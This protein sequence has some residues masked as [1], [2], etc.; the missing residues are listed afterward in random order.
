MNYLAHIFL[1]RHSDDA[2]VGALL[3]DFVKAGGQ[4]LFP[5]EVAR[6]IQLHRYIDS[7]TDSHPTVRAGVQLFGEGRRRYAGIVLDVFYDHLLSRRW[8]DYSGSPKA[9]LIQRFYQAVAQYEP[10][11]PERLRAILPRM[12]AQDWLGSYEDL[13]SVELAVNRIS[14]RL[15]RNGHLMREGLLDLRQHQDA[16]A[17]GFDQFFPELIRF[18]ELKRGEMRVL[19]WI[20]EASE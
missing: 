10:L 5:P 6:E 18:V 14:Q 17:A 8:A 12:V 16:L 11:L 2:M 4:T 15:S 9:E 1:A 13:V 7:Y 3:G 19:P 20:A